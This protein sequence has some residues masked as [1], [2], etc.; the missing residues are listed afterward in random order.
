MQRA[1]DKL[2]KDLEALKKQAKPE[3]PVKGKK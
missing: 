3:A 2:T 1:N